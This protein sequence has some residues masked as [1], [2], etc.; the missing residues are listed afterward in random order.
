MVEHDTD[1]RRQ[2]TKARDSALDK[3]EMEKVRVCCLQDHSTQALVSTR[4]ASLTVE[5][6]IVAVCRLCMAMGQLKDDTMSW[7]YYLGYWALFVDAKNFKTDRRMQIRLR[8]ST[9]VAEEDNGKR[10]IG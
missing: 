7:S 4:L 8:L 3:F 2:V 10:F 1:D 5:Q 9:D 6:T